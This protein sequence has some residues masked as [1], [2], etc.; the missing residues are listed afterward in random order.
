MTTPDTPAPAPDDP[1]QEP[2]CTPQPAQMLAP[3]LSA[4]LS[5]ALTDAALSAAWERVQANGGAAGADHQT[6]DAFGRHMAD[7]LQRL[8]REVVSGDYAPQPL[9]LVPI[10]KA[11]GGQRVLAIPVVRDRVLQTAVAWLI[12]SGQVH[13]HLV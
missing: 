6:V 7:E 11:R 1:L 3:P 5:D 2:A 12:A 13:Y 10:P 8:R 9:Q 4:P